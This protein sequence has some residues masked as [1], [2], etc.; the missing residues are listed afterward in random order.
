VI[1]GPRT[2]VTDAY[3]GPYTA[4]GADVVI[5]GMEIQH[6]IV[7]DGAHLG[8]IGA[9]LEDSIVGRNARV[10]RDLRLPRATRLLV[11]DGAEVSL[12]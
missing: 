11:A 4:V 2:T 5:E 12:S 9:R 1:I 7:L 3:V 10:D 8:F 6:S